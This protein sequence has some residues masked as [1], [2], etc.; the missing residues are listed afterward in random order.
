MVAPKASSRL[1]PRRCLCVRMML[2]ELGVMI[3][4]SLSRI[5]RAAFCEHEFFRANPR[6]KCAG[7][8]LFD[9]DEMIPCLIVATASAA[10]VSSNCPNLNP[11]VSQFANH[12]LIIVECKQNG[13]AAEF[14]KFDAGCITAPT[15]QIP[16]AESSECS[17]LIKASNHD[18]IPA[19]CPTC[20]TAAMLAHY[21]AADVPNSSDA[22]ANY[23]RPLGLRY[24]DV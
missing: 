9:P 5:R 18:P 7:S 8:G 19:P 3:T 23:T 16:V 4:A 13:T 10:P 20:R 15:W 22:G 24:P 17:R 1:F 14:L 21:N 11:G 12:A 2:S 6:E